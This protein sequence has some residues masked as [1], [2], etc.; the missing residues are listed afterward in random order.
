MSSS[1]AS[2]SALP[3]EVAAR[4]ARRRRVAAGAQ[5]VPDGTEAPWASSRSESSPAIIA[6][7]TGSHQRQTASRPI[8][9]PV[10]RPSALP[11]SIASG[12]IRPGS[13][14][15]TMRVGGIL[16]ARSHRSRPNPFPTAVAR[17]EMRIVRPRSAG[18]G[19][20]W[21]RG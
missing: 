12:E 7:S 6:S 18:G 9:A 2:W 3:T 11:S 19:G 4:T 13:S 8:G 14:A 21:R 5:A 17:G 15:M 1:A 20:S 10:A 16:H